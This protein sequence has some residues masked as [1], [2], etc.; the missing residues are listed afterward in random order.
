MKLPMLAVSALALLSSPAL[1]Q[2]APPASPAKPGAPAAQ[3]SETASSQVAV[4]AARRL[5]GENVHAKD[6]KE[7]GEIEYLMVGVNDGQVRYA[8]VEPDEG[9]RNEMVPVPWKAI[10]MRGSGRESDLVVDRDRF[11]KQKKF[12]E[13]QIGDLTQ[14]EVIT[15]IYDYWAPVTAPQGKGQKSGEATG[16]E[17]GQ[18]KTSQGTAQSTP[19]F[20]VGRNVLTTI[21]AP[22]FRTTEE[23]RGSEV[24]SSD[25]G[26]FGEINDLMIDAKQGRVAYVQVGHGG[27]L[28]LGEE[29]T[30][31]PFEALTY[32]HERNAYRLGK[33]EAELEKI[34]RFARAEEPT[35]VR[36]SDLNRLY[37]DFGV[38]PYWQEKS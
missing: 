28:G 37:E 13:D 21:Y 5:V 2:T 25:N 35:S 9:N 20:L 30:P 10:Q 17:A 34:Q 3:T 29:I 1:A 27:F 33:T 36:R 12:T 31:V 19:H 15:S 23:I 16:K 11:A 18:A 6:G 14:P 32:D 8:I 24:Y 22:A 7:L 26:E 4:V 38:Q